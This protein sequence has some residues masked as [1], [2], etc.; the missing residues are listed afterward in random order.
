MNVWLQLSVVYVAVIAAW[1]LAAFCF[2]Q[3][4]MTKFHTDWLMGAA[5]A[6]FVDESALDQ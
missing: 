6:D 4:P 2:M 1:L 3:I 5:R